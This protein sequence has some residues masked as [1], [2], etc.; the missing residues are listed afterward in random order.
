LACADLAKDPVHCG[1]CGHD[2]LGGGCTDKQCDPIEMTT[3]A[4]QGLDSLHGL[5]ADDTHLYIASYFGANTA[6]V[7]EDGG[8]L[9][10]VNKVGPAKV[11][12]IGE[13]EGMP[14]YVFKL[15]ERVFW[16]SWFQGTIHSAA[17]TPTTFG[18][19]VQHGV[20]P[21]LGGFGI[22]GTGTR[23]F[24]ASFGRPG[25]IVEVS[26][27]VPSGDAG[28]AAVLVP[29]QD[30]PRVLA[31]DGTDLFWSTKTAINAMALS[32]PGAPIRKLA[33]TQLGWGIALDGQWVYYSDKDGGVVGRIRKDAAPGS[34]PEVLA[35]N[36][37]GIKTLRF[38]GNMLYAPV[39]DKDRVVR[40]DVTTKVV[41]TL[42]VGQALASD[43]AV[44]AKF[45]YWVNWGDGRVMKVAK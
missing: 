8:R 2:C 26:A 22:T 31:T 38:D 36:L 20:A 11:E 35:T 9:L 41:T 15:A 45:V 21:G 6:P 42:A 5:W 1:T 34:M 17:V 28:V 13:R 25:S 43:V 18:P 24:M 3:L 16:S 33:T 19:V 39:Y 30:E 32:P 40:I 10:R 23:V 29:A 4:P 44:D 12:V 27:A 14:T 7:H 37:S